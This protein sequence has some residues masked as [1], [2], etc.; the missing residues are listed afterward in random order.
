MKNWKFKKYL[1]TVI[2][3]LLLISTNTQAY[4]Q[5]SENDATLDTIESIG[6]D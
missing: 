2:Y 5:S 4:A 1:W 6:R 3:L